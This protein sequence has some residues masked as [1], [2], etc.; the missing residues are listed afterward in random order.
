ML[1]SRTRKVLVAV[2]ASVAFAVSSLVTAQ[3]VGSHTAA[4]ASI[5]Q[6]GTIIP[7]MAETPVTIAPYL[8][9]QLA[10]VDIDNSVFQGLLRYSYKNKPYGLIASKWKVSKN[11]LHYTFYLN[12]KARWSDGKPVTAKDVVFT[13]KLVTNPSFPATGVTSQQYIKTIK[14]T[15]KYQ[16]DITLKS[17]YAPFLRFYGSSY[18][19]PQHILGSMDPASI[20][21][22][23]QWSRQ[24]VGSG[25]FKIT[26]YAAGDHITETAVKN[27]WMGNNR[28]HLKQI[29]F[30]IVPSGDTAAQQLQTGE[31]TMGMN[32]S[33]LTVQNYLQLMKVPNV[34]VYKFPTFSWTHADLIETGFLKDVK[35]RQA[36][37]MATPKQQIIKQVDFGY[38]T[39]QYSDQA[40]GRKLFYD[41]SVTKYWPY[42]LTK[43]AQALAADGFTKDSSG[44]LSKGGVPFD[45]TLYGLAGSTAT[46]DIQEILK[47]NWNKLGIGVTLKTE[48]SATLFGPR[49]PLYDPNRLS[50]PTMNIVLY[51]WITGPDP[52]DSFFWGCDKIVSATVKSGGNFDG[53]CNPTVDKLVHQ[54]VTTASV[55]KRQAIYKKAQDII[56]Q[57]VPDI[58]INWQQGFAVATKKLG[59]FHPTPYINGIT[60]D[61]ENWFMNP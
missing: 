30:R 21:K 28:P 17:V 25:P 27:W 35:V 41:K 47:A 54:G 16:V 59:N 1:P 8:N 20:S 2:G 10:L 42:D 50:S 36:L 4:A 56:A 48:D 57:Q 23:V 26:Q 32:D 38:G 9:Q 61:A 37:T 55:K 58:F 34:K 29:I 49:G 31:V 43:A 18:V 19:V 24:P 11:G 60:N 53:Y 46:A 15:N 39:P 22:N 6:G 7:A 12:P 3:T 5:P 44:N 33:N 14:A 13:E 45:V 40:P 52:D 51:G